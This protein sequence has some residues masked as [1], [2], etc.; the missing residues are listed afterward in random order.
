MRYFWYWHTAGN[1]LYILTQYINLLNKAHLRKQQNAFP[2]ALSFSSSLS[3]WIVPCLCS[4]CYSCKPWPLLRLNGWS[5]NS[6]YLKKCFPWH[7]LIALHRI[8]KIIL[9]RPEFSIQVIIY[10]NGT[11]EEIMKK[12]HTEK[13]YTIFK[14]TQECTTLE[15]IIHFG[16]KLVSQ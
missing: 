3:L 9:K 6:D 16:S 14:F 11:V 5:M 12:K 13:Q 7:L 2:N 10:W 4:H 15:N 8:S 1:L